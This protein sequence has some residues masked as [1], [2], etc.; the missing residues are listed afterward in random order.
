MMA[1]CT[2]RVEGLKVALQKTP[3]SKARSK[4]AKC[5]QSL[6]T[7]AA[8]MLNIEA[9]VD[10]SVPARLLP[11]FA[12]PA[13]AGA[14]LGGAAAVAGGSSSVVGSSSVGGSTEDSEAAV[15]PVRAD[16]AAS[17]S[18]QSNG[19][20][21]TSMTVSGVESSFKDATVLRRGVTHSS[22]PGG[23]STAMANTMSEIHA[24]PTPSKLSHG[25]LTDS[26]QI[27]KRPKYPVAQPIN[28]L[29]R[30]HMDC[31]M[32]RPTRRITIGIMRLPTIQMAP[33][34]IA[35]GWYTG[36]CKKDPDVKS[37]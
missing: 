31:P 19:L 4:P 28:M 29:L 3:T 26:F 21:S 27:P 11:L 15:A 33:P 23:S 13:P 5:P 14:T 1:S 35:T 10:R 24:R 20:P 18:S 36:P 37:E 32:P 8:I 25:F 2:N 17:T 7:G 34:N 6:R 22:P 12:V 30:S 16:P 9:A